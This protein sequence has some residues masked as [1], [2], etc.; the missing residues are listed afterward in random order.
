LKTEVHFADEFERSRQRRDCDVLAKRSRR[1]A[2]TNRKISEGFN[3]RKGLFRR[4][5]RKKN[6]GQPDNSAYSKANAQSAE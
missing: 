5:R 4:E 1:K 3:A 2:K 6:T